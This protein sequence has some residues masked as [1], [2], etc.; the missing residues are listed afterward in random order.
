MVIW[1]GVEANNDHRFV[2]GDYTYFWVVD[3][4]TNSD[5]QLSYPPK[6]GWKYHSRT[7]TIKIKVG[8]CVIKN[9]IVPTFTLYPYFLRVFKNKFIDQFINGLIKLLICIGNLNIEGF[10]PPT[11]W[12]SRLPEKAMETGCIEKS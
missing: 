2:I 12:I 6:F 11:H 5:T 9:Q 4:L 8:G 3:F 7:F 10:P 1:V